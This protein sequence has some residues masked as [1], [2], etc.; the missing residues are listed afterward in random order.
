MPVIWQNCQPMALTATKTPVARR[1]EAALTA[2][3]VSG[4][5]LEKTGAIGKGYSSYIL[6]G[7]RR[8]LRPDTIQAIADALRI[9]SVWLESGEGPMFLPGQ[10]ED[11]PPP[12]FEKRRRATKTRSHAAPSP[13]PELEEDPY[14]NRRAFRQTTEFLDAP[15]EVQ[16][17]LVGIDRDEGDLPIRG[18]IE[19]LE[20]GMKLRALGALHSRGA[21]P[22][23]IPGDQS[24]APRQPDT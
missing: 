18:W 22:P 12:G 7:S 16:D 24:E 1:L 21:A 17:W 4:T 2:R 11:W 5:W 19:V 23:T 14:V 8:Y 3:E 20:L 15:R 9:S 10:R 13:M 6:S